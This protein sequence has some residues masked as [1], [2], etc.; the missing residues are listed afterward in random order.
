MSAL[1]K[2]AQSN[3]TATGRVADARQTKCK[4][5]SSPRRTDKNNALAAR[6]QQYDNGY[7]E[8]AR[9]AFESGYAS[10]RQ[11]GHLQRQAAAR[12]NR[13]NA[14]IRATALESVSE[15]NHREHDTPRAKKHGRGEG[16]RSSAKSGDGGNN[17]DDSAADPSFLTTQLLNQASFADLLCVSK[18][19][20]QN[21]YSKTPWLLPVAI[22]IPGARGPRWT[23][24]AVQEW[25]QQRPQHAPQ[26][27]PHQPAKKVG[28]PRIAS[29][30]ARSAS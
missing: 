15:D 28:R 23:H 3:L 18:K 29:H 22:V 14:A 25:L 20:L 17:D 8:D 5:P 26:P 9:N 1:T 16:M 2:S 12:A 7:D 24:K 27:A 4:Q 21:L 6:R 13:I 30:S 11:I 10:I 19:T